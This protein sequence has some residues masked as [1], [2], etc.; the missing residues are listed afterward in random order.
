VEVTE[1]QNPTISNSQIQYPSSKP[2]FTKRSLL[3]EIWSLAELIIG[4]GHWI[5]GDI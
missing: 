1:V 5:F 2:Q 4:I 3:F